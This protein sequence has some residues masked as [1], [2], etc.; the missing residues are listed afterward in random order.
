MVKFVWLPFLVFAATF[1]AL[2]PG[3]IT[4]D[5][6]EWKDEPVKHLV[7]RGTL[8]RDTAFHVLLPRP[9]DRKNRIIT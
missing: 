9:E 4:I 5:S 3:T 1:S 7:V 8:N 2:Q 6:Q